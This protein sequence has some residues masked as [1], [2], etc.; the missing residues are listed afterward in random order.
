MS[1]CVGVAGCALLT[2]H[3]AARIAV[4]IVRMRIVLARRQAAAGP[5][6]ST[7]ECRFCFAAADA[8]GGDAGTLIRP[9]EC[10]GTQAYVHDS[11]LQAW[12][13]ESH[14][15]RCRVC[16]SPFLLL[17]GTPRLAASVLDAARRSF[18]NVTCA[19]CLP[20]SPL[21]PPHSAAL[22]ALLLLRRPKCS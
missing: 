17:R 13:A 15:L 10:S 11:C 8:D 12:L 4:S 21:P 5:P 20:P 14:D 22:G 7:A 18:R 2:A 16:R 6:P 1:T 3:S 19:S 9:C